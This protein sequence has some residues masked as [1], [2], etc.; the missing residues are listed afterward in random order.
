MSSTC[1]CI[2]WVHTFPL[3]SSNFNFRIPSST[4][5]MASFRSMVKVVR[6]CRTLSAGSQRETEAVYLRTRTY[7]IWKGIWGNSVTLYRKASRPSISSKINREVILNNPENQCLVPVD[8]S[9]CNPSMVSATQILALNRNVI[10]A[11]LIISYKNIE[12]V[13]GPGC[14]WTANSITQSFIRNVLQKYWCGDSLNCHP[15]IY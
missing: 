2:S 10:S 14:I 6:C 1:R 8:I 11:T 7:I 4:V 9:P 15:Y 3:A 13:I 5:S 12:E